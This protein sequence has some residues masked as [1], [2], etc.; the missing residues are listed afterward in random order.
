MLIQFILNGIVAG[1]VYALVALGFSL[2]Y[3]TLRFF[4][5]AHG[6]VFTAGAYTAYAVLRLGQPVVVAVLTAAVLGS[7]LGLVI[8]GLVY[9]PLYKRRASS[10][11]LFLASLGVYIF[12]QN[13]I[14][15]I[16]GDS[17]KVLLQS[18]YI[19]VY[20]VFGAT[21]TN[22]DCWILATSCC[23]WL[24][25]WWSLRHSRLGKLLRAVANDPELC[26]I[27]GIS[28]AKVM[29]GTMMIGSLL[30]A[31]AGVLFAL[32]FNATPVMG[33]RTLLGGITA[34]I[35][36]GVENVLGGYMGAII[37]GVL[38]HLGVW[39]LSTQWQDA[40][41]YVLLLVVLLVRPSGILSTGKARSVK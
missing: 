28:A 41:L 18:R 29:T 30:S 37:V 25:T 24:A 26:T 20:H 35:V 27:F 4:H 14:A 36:G 3:R 19:S 23:A 1:S 7:V 32:D 34:T 12:L 38:Q 33:F 8:D 15:M 2:V 39:K 9:R 6:A 40:I 10:M 31:I 11:V 22:M 21:L 16:F 13:A 5:F 17:S